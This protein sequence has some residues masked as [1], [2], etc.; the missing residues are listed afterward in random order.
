M[1]KRLTEEVDNLVEIFLA[2]NG[3]ADSR[4]AA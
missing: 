3:F 2:E 1:V 4:P